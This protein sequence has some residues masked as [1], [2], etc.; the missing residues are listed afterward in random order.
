[1]EQI[2]G[3]I[4]GGGGDLAGILSTLNVVGYVSSVILLVAV[5]FT[6]LALFDASKKFE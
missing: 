4:M 6:S 2:I 1:M 5:L 3:N